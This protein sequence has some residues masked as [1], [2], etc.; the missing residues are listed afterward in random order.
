MREAKKKTNNIRFLAVGIVFFALCAVFLVVLGFNQAKGSSLPPKAEG[1]TRTYTVSGLRGEIYDCNGKKLVANTDKYDIV[2][3]YGAMPDTR[4]EVNRALL[5]V[6]SAIK[7]TGNELRLSD[8][9]FI[10]EGTYPNM[11]F[12]SEMSDKESNEYYHYKKFL[13]RN[14]LKEGDASSVADYFVDR[15]SLDDSEYTPSEITTLIRLYYEMERVDFGSYQSYTIATEVSDSLV[16]A[17]KESGVEGVSFGVS[18]DRIYLYP[19]Y[20]SHILGRLGKITAENADYYLGLGYEVDAYV[21]TSGCEAAFEEY[22]RGSDG[23]LCVE[24]DNDGKVIKS[25]YTK[26]P[27][28]GKDIYLTIDIDLQ[29]AAEDALAENVEMIE[30]SD[31]GA[32]TVL[33]PNSGKI[34]AVASYPTFDLTQF[35]SKEYYNSL[36]NDEHLP[37]YNRALQGVYAPGST[38]KIGVALAALEEGIIDVSYCYDCDKF[39]KGD[40]T[41]PSCLGIHDSI[42]VVE[43]IRESCNIFFYNLGEIMGIEQITEYTERLGLG[44]DSGLELG[45]KSGIVAGP[46]YRVENGLAAW[47]PG[48]DLSAAIGQ[49]D[50]GYTPLQLSIYIS[51]VVNGG[52]RYK[53]HLLDSVREFYTHGVV[54]E[55]E[56]EVCDEV[57]FSDGTY[58]LLIDAMRQVVDSNPTLKNDYFANVPVTVGG[59]TGTAEVS[60]KKDYSV[61][62][63]FAPLESPEIVISCILEEG[64]YGQRAAYA[65]GKIMEKYFEKYGTEIGEQIAA[66][67]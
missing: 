44:A 21:G 27:K 43:A 30:S 61:F 5:T 11:R 35:E 4:E 10:L 56:T 38:Y 39:Y 59:K 53:A 28:R 47:Q 50:H 7:S 26:E 22:L 58:D 32:L 12:V 29:I 67:E 16:S 23:E 42:N 41:G 8:D 51:S 19:G 33:D 13:E 48:D 34:L 37:L 3:E 1:Y 17:I 46:D 55:V 60:G 6:M 36:V 52:K 9:Y 64:E 20:A 66:A 14:Q 18:P 24:Y 25:Y 63:G 2:Y 49:S 57:E 45:N 15:Y 62:C 65:V 31:A 54:S 40:P